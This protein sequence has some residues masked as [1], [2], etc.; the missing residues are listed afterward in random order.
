MSEANELIVPGQNGL[1]LPEKLQ[2]YGVLTLNV[3]EI[4]EV[5]RENLGG[6]ALT[7]ADLDRIKI[8]SGGGTQWTIE[9]LDGEEDCKE[10]E[11]IIVHWKDARVYWSKEYDGS[12]NPPDCHSDNIIFGIG[13]PGGDCQ[14][15]PYS[16]FGSSPK[17][18]SNGQ[19]CKQIRVLFIV[20]PGNLL[21]VVLTLP[22]TS[23][24]AAKNYFMRLASMNRRYWSMTTRFT[25]EKDKNSGGITYSKVKVERGTDIPADYM[26]ELRRFVE[27]IK[28]VLDNAV[29][30]EA[31][32]ANAE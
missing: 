7:P 10:F 6:N 27:S 11:G 1:M 18:G 16:K 5:M 4:G 12:K 31:E 13:T 24:P 3:Q 9:G 19:A 28:P 26:A 22:P 30:V 20:R 29:T 15:C 14:T 32:G 21:P 2:N 8:P 23:I 25:L 17:E